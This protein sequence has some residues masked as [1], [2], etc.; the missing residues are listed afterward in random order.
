MQPLRAVLF[1]LDG[2][3][4][5]SIP[6]ILD[7]YA[8]TF[9]HFG[10]PLPSRDELIA[11]IGVPLWVVFRRLGPGAP[12]VDGMIA[13]YREYNLAHHDSRAGAFPGVGEMVREV[14]HRRLATALVTSKLRSS[15]V[16]GLALLGLETAMDT[17]IGAD[18]VERPKPDPQPVQLALE[19]LGVTPGAA[20]FVGDSVHNLESGR[21]AG[22]RTAAAL[23]GAPSRVTLE[24]GRPDFWLEQPLDLVALLPPA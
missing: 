10:L 9:A 20:L 24:A 2:T 14:R 11:D 19:R 17:I 16:R 5:D 1:D 3:L 7:S 8:H 4:L 21:A 13:V 23:W 6:L 15:A 22:T 12:A 18:D